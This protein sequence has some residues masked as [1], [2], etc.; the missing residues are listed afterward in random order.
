MST[1]QQ[2]SAKWPGSLIIDTHDL[3]VWFSGSVGQ[4]GISLSSKQIA[5]IVTQIFH[6]FLNGGEV[7]L[8]LSRLPN[9][10]TLH[11]ADQYPEEQK[12][13]IRHYAFELA[14]RLLSRTT[15]LGAWKNGWFPYAF[16][17]FMG[18]D[19]VLFHLPY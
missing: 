18:R 13:I 11:Y 6:V 3:L 7:L 14:Q 1:V 12:A 9:F 4:H 15:E 17:H 10:Q 5:E 19:V 16:D 2:D 8:E